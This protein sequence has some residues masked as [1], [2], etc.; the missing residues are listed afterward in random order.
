LLCAPDRGF[1]AAT[2]RSSTVLT[3]MEKVELARRL[4]KE[5]TMSLKWI[6]EQLEMGSWTYVSNLLVGTTKSLGSKD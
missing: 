3:Q 5:T 4:R 1:V 6:A 2:S